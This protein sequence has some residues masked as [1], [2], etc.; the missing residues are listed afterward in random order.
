MGELT[1]IGYN[2][3]PVRPSFRAVHPPIAVLVD[4]TV[5]FPRAPHRTGTYQ[6][7]GLQMHKVVEGTL[8]C[9]GLCEQGDWWGL[10]SYEIAYGSKRKT[11]THWVPAWTLKPSTRTSGSS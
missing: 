7:H 9:W 11:V 1:S 4:L 8:S 6:P 10:V 5:L 2:G 3:Q